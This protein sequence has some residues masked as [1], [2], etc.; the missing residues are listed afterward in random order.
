MEVDATRSEVEVEISDSVQGSR[1]KQKDLPGPTHTHLIKLTWTFNTK[2][3]YPM[4]PGL[5]HMGLNG[6]S[7][8]MRSTP[9]RRLL[10]QHLFGDF[11]TSVVTTGAENGE[12]GLGEGPP[13]RLKKPT[14]NTPFQ[15]GAYEERDTLGT[16]TH[17]EA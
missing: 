10:L 17:L 8:N 15:S 5:E 6:C 13:R 16:S 12:N 14:G 2:T 7:L 1:L 9:G 3:P 11:F 4:L